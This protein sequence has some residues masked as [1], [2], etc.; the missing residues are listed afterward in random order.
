METN[1]ATL[2]NNEEKHC[3]LNDIFD[4][5]Y[6]IHC[7]ENSERMKNIQYQINLIHQ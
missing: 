1:M 2:L 6:V 5:I 7:A 3:I 4:K